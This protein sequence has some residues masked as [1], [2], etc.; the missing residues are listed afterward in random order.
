M[1]NII[2][3]TMSNCQLDMHRASE[4][5]SVFVIKN[6]T[7]MATTNKKAVLM[8]NVKG[9]ENLEGTI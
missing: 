3:C 6:I 5:C 9:Y 7:N 4:F 8:R 2:V 1:I